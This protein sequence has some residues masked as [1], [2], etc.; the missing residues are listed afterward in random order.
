[1]TERDDLLAIVAAAQ[2][3]AFTRA[4]AIDRGY[5]PSAVKRRVASG[6]W[7]PDLP[8]VLVIPGTPE[9]ETQ[10]NWCIQLS[11]G[12]RS[13]LSHQTAGRM[14]DLP[15]IA[16]ETQACIVPHF[17]H[18]RRAGVE[19]H[20]MKLD[21]CDVVVV[22]D[23][24]YTGLARTVC[25]L[26][27][28][29]SLPR[30]RT[31]VEAAL[32]DRG[33]SQAALGMALLR[34]GVLGR[35]RGS[36]LGVVLD[37]LSPGGAI[38]S[39]RLEVALSEILELAGIGQGTTQYPLPNTGRRSGLTDRGFPEATLLLEADGRRWH[40]RQ[41]AMSADHERDLEASR[42]GWHT[43]RIMYEQIVNDPADLAKAIAETYHH[44]LRAA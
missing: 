16:A 36:Q 7:R 13:V 35:T 34:V 9:S 1:M 3:G 15:A 28:I 14:F 26:S 31:I 33:L 41:K 38:A 11:L 24:R 17:D 40:A 42:R 2:A 4:Q 20:Q 10:R 37:E 8:G 29:L 32:F 6:R 27:T 44:R 23:L 39:S 43:I 18:R 30:V 19:L 25:D 22:D 12:E 5:T 21:P